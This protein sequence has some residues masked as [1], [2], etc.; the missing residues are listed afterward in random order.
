MGTELI[1]SEVV[2]MWTKDGLTTGD[3][4][5]NRGSY[6]HGMLL[7][8]LQSAY[9]N[10]HQVYLNEKQVIALIQTLAASLDYSSEGHIPHPVRWPQTPLN[11]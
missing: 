4:S 11:D 1:T 3:I 7:I 8:H 5:I 9:N 6:K 2:Y 10:Y